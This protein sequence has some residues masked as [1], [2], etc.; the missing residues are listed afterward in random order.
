MSFGKGLRNAEPEDRYFFIDRLTSIISVVQ[1]EIT[2]TISDSAGETASMES[3]IVRVVSL[4]TTEISEITRLKIGC[5]ESG[6]LKKNEYGHL[7]TH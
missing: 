4:C 3:E 1:R 7:R 2:L 5:S 6:Y